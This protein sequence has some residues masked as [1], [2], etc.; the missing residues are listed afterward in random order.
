[1]NC[2]VCG[3]AEFVQHAILWP[4]L[5]ADWELSPEEAAYVDEQQGLTCTRCKVNLRAMTLASAI[6][7]HFGYGGLFRD[8][9]AGPLAAMDVLEIN[10]ANQLTKDLWSSPR[11]LLAKYPQ[12]DMRAMPYADAAFDLVIHSDTLEHVPDPVAALRECR[13]VL[14]PGG[15]LAYTVPIIVG[16][17]SRSRAGLKDSFHGS[18]EPD[19]LVVTEYGA[20]AWCEA[21]EAGFREVKLHALRYPSSIAILARK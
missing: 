3:S 15:V 8:F 16:R 7:A 5:I 9:C 2:P 19:N 11:H 17:R 20:D 13:R 21:M 1:M 14:R 4:E 6:M 12:V 10:E 18:G